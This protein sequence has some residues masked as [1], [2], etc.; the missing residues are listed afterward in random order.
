[1]E[2]TAENEKKKPDDSV[3][4]KVVDHIVIKDKTEDKEVLRKRG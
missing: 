2:N 3:Q 1:M 4:I